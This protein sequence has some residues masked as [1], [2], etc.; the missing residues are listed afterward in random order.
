ME[1]ATVALARNVNA[2]MWDGL[3]EEVLQVKILI[4]Q[5]WQLEKKN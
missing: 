2:G 1:R 4:C 5:P 3:E